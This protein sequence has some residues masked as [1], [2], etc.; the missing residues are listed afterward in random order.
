MQ[1]P[2][3]QEQMGIPA[4]E[5]IEEADGSVIIDIGEEQEPRKFSDNLAEY[6]TERELNLLALDLFEMIDRDKQ[7]RS[8]RDEQYE[9]GIR[10]TGLGEDAPGGAKFAGASKVVHPVMAEACID[11][12]ARAIKELFPS[13]GPI[14]V[15][16]D[17]ILPP[18]QEF[19]V[20]QLA[21][22]LNNQFT[23]EIPEYRP[24]YEI[25]LT[26]LPL[27]GSQYTKF[28]P[29][30][31][32]D[33]IGTEFVPIDDLF[34]PYNVQEFY[35]TPRLTHRQYPSESTYEE[36]VGNGMYRDIKAIK[37]ASDPEK[38]ASALAS[39]KI[40]GKESSGVNEDGDRIVYEMYT[41]LKL[42]DDEITGGIRSP[43]I[44]VLD[45]EEQS[46]LSIRRNW[47]EQ[48]PLRRKLD[49]IVDDTFIPWRGAQ[50][51][52]LPHL[53]GGL[54]AAA[55]GSLRALLDSAH[56]NNAP[57]LL[58]LKGSRINGTTQSV[59][60]TQ[61]ADIEGPV[62]MDDIRK[63]IMPMPFNP[64][65]NV[66]F[67]LLGWLTEAAKG[68]V[69]TASEKIAD[70]T[71]NTPVGTTQAI[72]EQGA[73]IF[74]SI[75]ARLHY[76]QAKK[77]D[78]V[79]RLLKR[80][81]PEKLQAYQIDPQIVSLR[82]IQPVSDPR[83]FSEAQRF[84]QMQGVM[85]LAASAPDRYNLVE[86][87]KEMLSLM[88]VD[89][90]AIGR[91]LIVPP[92]PQPGDPAVEMISFMTDKPVVVVPEQDHISHIRVHINYL[93]DPMCGRNPIMAPI[94]QKI[95]DHLKA[96]IGHFF[97]KRLMN[98]AQS[99]AQKLMPMLP[100]QHMPQNAPGSVQQGPQLPVEAIMADASDQFVEHDIEF[101]QDALV[102][103][104]E[105]VDFL[106]SFQINA[107]VDPT[108]TST[109]MLT[110]AQA[111][112]T[113]RKRQADE[114]KAENDRLKTM[115][116][117]ADSKNKADAQV[118]KDL[119]QARA[120]GER[121]NQLREEGMLDAKVELWKNR[122]DNAT[123]LQVE[124]AK[125]AQKELSEKMPEQPEPKGFD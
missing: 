72:I 70:A 123:I 94:T 58:K 60:V 93:K 107:I 85:Q 42:D 109:E 20:K 64:P 10:R 102:I 97:A 69:S 48:D 90:S 104:Q 114:L 120:D 49:W 30:F 7:A 46:I 19:Q 37:A 34:L 71:S 122:E 73:I 80:Y 41:Y 33:K 44:V 12:S 21:N 119:A 83:I 14:K 24:T 47:E 79:L 78:I 32:N 39:E 68:V 117:I 113:E 50:G 35:T 27:G 2:I 62:G 43:Y 67:Q 22:C 13:G 59:A 15:Q 36:R 40:E 1:S 108:I 77:F 66:L 38:S 65:S 100:P 98:A 88:K 95:L 86:L 31:A 54:S 81:F 92:E 18:E 112:E 4:D 26:Q 115:A 105:T 57:T 55:T 17:L 101:A 16:S 75:H 89:A 91:F 96:H 25:L 99:V 116:F 87:H 8:R 125:L 53:I 63:Y 110:Q 23:K 106:K 76:S 3:D 28:Y 29:D 52:G 103:I 111:I 5:F 9:E 61:I 11:F 45:E 84:A 121:I 124:A 51:I 74:S 56:I 6:I 82:G 118:Q